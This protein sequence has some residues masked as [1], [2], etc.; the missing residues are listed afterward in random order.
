[1][2]KVVCWSTK[3]AR[4]GGRTGHN[5]AKSE[6]PLKRAHY[7][8]KWGISS[9]FL[10]FKNHF[11]LCDPTL[12]LTK[13]EA[14]LTLWVADCTVPSHTSTITRYVFEM[15]TRSVDNL[16]S[17]YLRELVWQS[18]WQLDTCPD[19]LN[20]ASVCELWHC[21]LLVPSCQCPRQATPMHCGHVV[22]SSQILNNIS[23][24]GF[25]TM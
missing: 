19:W 15:S 12:Q 1:V 4:H 10:H 7:E 22:H 14:Q 5:L 23:D 11:R 6:L 25:H 9:H 13:Q 20:C 17:S 3:V 16:R 8:A 24:V 18:S 2:E 21:A